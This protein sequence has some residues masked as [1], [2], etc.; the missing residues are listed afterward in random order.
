M[1]MLWPVTGRAVFLRP[2]VFQETATSFVS[3]FRSVTLP[4]FSPKSD[5]AA[6]IERRMPPVGSVLGDVEIRMR[7]VFVRS[8]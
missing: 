6:E 8:A 5:F 4:A 3:D 7:D 2:V 1:T